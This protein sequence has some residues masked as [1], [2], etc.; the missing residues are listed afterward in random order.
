MADI[1]AM[2]VVAERL[3]DL[4]ALWAAIESG[5]DARTARGSPCSTRRRWRRAPRSPTCLRV[6]P[7]GTG[8]AA[9]LARL[10][11]GIARLDRQTEALLLEEGRA[12]GLS[13]AQGLE[14]AGAPSGARRAGRA[15]VRHGRRGRPVGTGRAAGPQRDGADARL[16][17]AGAG[18]GARLGADHRRADRADRSRGSGC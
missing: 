3:F 11:G 7:P 15:A 8:P 13:I 6:T 16:H 17:A 2:F 5:A 9:V 4:P 1:A 18:A 14:A 10:A 12:Q